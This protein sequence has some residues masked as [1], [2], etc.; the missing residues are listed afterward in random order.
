MSKENTAT[1]VSYFV[2]SGVI[3]LGALTFNQ[4]M[5]LGGLFFSAL[6]FAV[7]AYFQYQRNQILKQRESK[8]DSDS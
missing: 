7:N 6:T 4:W 8:R 3:S 1:Q 5:A 2:N